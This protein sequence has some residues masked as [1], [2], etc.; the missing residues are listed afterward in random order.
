M[1]R[2]RVYWIRLELGVHSNPKTIA[3]A[4]SLSISEHAVVGHLTELWLWAARERP[5]GDLAGISDRA[6]D[7]IS[8]WYDP[9]RSLAPVLREVGYIKGTLISAWDDVNGPALRELERKRRNRAGTIPSER[10]V[11]GRTDAD[12]TGTGTLQEQEQEQETRVGSHARDHSVEDEAAEATCR[13]VDAWNE[14]FRLAVQ[15]RTIK[16]IGDRLEG[17]L[18]LGPRM[19]RA[20]EVYL[21]VVRR[22]PPSSEEYLINPD[23]FFGSKQRWLEYDDEEGLNR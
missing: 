14:A 4:E 6:I 3:A 7:R 5:D 11:Y 2:T 23:N 8:G 13:I 17:D 22:N 1:G 20:V 15:T 18:D 10:A 9:G 19:I 12:L 21:A 16:A